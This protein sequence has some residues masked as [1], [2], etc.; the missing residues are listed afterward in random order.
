MVGGQAVRGRG[1]R[2][3]RLRAGRQCR[4][5]HIARVQDAV[6]RRV[7][8]AGRDVLAAARPPPVA[9]QAAA[10]GRP[11]SGLGRRRGRQDPGQAAARPGA[12]GRQA[13]GGRMVAGR[14]PA[15]RLFSLHPAEPPLCD[16]RTRVRQGRGRPGAARGLRLRGGQR[17]HAAVLLFRQPRGG[18]A[19]GPERRAAGGHG[20]YARG[21]RP[22][23]AHRPGAVP[24]VLRAGAGRA[25]ARRQDRPGRRGRERRRRRVALQRQPQPEG[26]GGKLG[27]GPPE[28]R[29]AQRLCRPLPDRRQGQPPP[30]H[31]PAGRGHQG[32]EGTPGSTWP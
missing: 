27:P 26:H 8:G 4:S 9:G 15:R 16:R 14:Q 17:S 6:V 1:R 23:P 24:P 13:G 22:V 11:G 7:A 31:L 5:L 21:R 12:A 19:R 29:D 25:P 20:Q 32:T 18:A 30:R 2:A 10:G 28:G 3:A